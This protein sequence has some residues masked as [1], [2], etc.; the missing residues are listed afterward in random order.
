MELGETDGPTPFELWI[1]SSLHAQRRIED[2]TR[3]AAMDDL[4]DE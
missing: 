2:L 4:Y 3:I 1:A